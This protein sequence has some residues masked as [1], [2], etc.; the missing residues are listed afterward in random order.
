MKPGFDAII[1]GGGFAGLS[2][3]AALA[4]KGAR[5]LLLEKKPHLGGRAYSFRDAETGDAID[6]GQHLFMGCY[7]QT[8]RFLR[9]IGTEPLLRFPPGLRVD[10]ADSAGGTDALSCPGFLPPPW[11]LAVGVLGM[12]RLSLV[13]KL[14]LLKVGSALKR[15]NGKGEIDRLSVRQWLRSAGCSAE[16]QR[17]LL[18]PIALGALNDDPE[19]ASATGL[20]QV[21]REIFLSDSESSR[22]GLSCVGLSELYTGA[23]KAAIEKAGGEVRLSSRVSRILERDGKVVGLAL[24]SGETLETTAVVSTLAPWDLSRV[25]M[26]PALRGPWEELGSSP[27]ISLGLWLDREALRQPLLG[28]IGTEIQWVFNKSAIMEI[29]GPGQYLALVISGARRHLASGPKALLELALKELSACVPDF[30]RAGLRRWKVVKEP[31]ATL[32][33]VPGAEILRPEPGEGMPG[34]YWAGDWTRTGL[35]ATI[36]SAVV[37]GRRVAERISAGISA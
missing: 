4:A 23:A 33:P 13:D 29:P 10:F 34:F 24:D 32:S 8:R 9:D 16:L 3:G 22:L 25:E 28:L 30:P 7:R 18:D 14:S 1:V 5:A 12:R 20:V 21:L 2:C 17:R 19:I 31:F 26:P 36:E 37:S 15:H 11:N 6:N 27:I 35:P